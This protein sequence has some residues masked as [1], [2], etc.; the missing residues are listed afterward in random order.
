MTQKL[1]TYDPGEDLASEKAIAIFMVEA[2]ETNDVSYIP[3]ALGVVA[4]ATGMAQIVGLTELPHV[5]LRVF[6]H[7]HGGGR[8]S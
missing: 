7:W 4:R 2:F 1:T 6:G 5:R 8:T 3:H